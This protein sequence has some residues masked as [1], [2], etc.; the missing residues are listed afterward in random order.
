MPLE[1]DSFAAL[2]WQWE[3]GVDEA[4]AES[5]VDWAALALPAPAGT[6]RLAGVVPDAA[7]GAAVRAVPAGRVSTAAPANRATS[8]AMAVSAGPGVADA[9]AAAAS[10]PSLAAL[11]EVISRFEGCS[12]KRT[13]MSLVFADGNPDAGLMLV[14][15]APGE[16]E[17]RQGRPFVGASGKLLDR[18]LAAIGRDRSRAYIANILPWRPPGNRTPTLEEI[19][20]CLPFIERHIALVDPRVLVLLGGVSAKTLLNRAEGIARLRGKWLDFTPAG[21]VRA[22]PTLATYHPAYL[23]RTPI[24]KREAWRDFLEIKSRML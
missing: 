7:M 8:A 24:H 18:M 1:N 5:P 15:E 17:D 23:L 6:T 21:G 16:D 22:I 10:A 12:L 13:A 2:R 20:L 4:I 19:A 11:V 9:R 3:I 14:G